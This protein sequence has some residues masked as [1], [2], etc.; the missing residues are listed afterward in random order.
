M[1]LYPRGENGSYEAWMPNNVRNHPRQRLLDLDTTQVSDRHQFNETFDTGTVQPCKLG[2]DGEWI[3]Q[4]SRQREE[5][6]V[7][8]AASQI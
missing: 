1:H 5:N 8:F 7:S 4:V 3:S 2:Y 6:S